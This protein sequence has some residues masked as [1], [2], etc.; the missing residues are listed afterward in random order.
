M[1][2]NHLSVCKYFCGHGKSK[3]PLATYR[4]QR[5]SR[6]CWKVLG[7]LNCRD[8]GFMKPGNLLKHQGAA[9]DHHPLLQTLLSELLFSAGMNWFLRVVLWKCMRLETTRCTVNRQPEVCPKLDNG[10]AKIVNS[11]IFLRMSAITSSCIDGF[12]L[13][14][15]P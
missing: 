3:S 5:R 13:L 2:W 7:V 8:L 9:V 11:S 14:W 15:L 12:E 10:H 4:L 6:Q 1:A